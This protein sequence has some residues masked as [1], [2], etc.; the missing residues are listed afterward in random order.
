M[1]ILNGITP[2]FSLPLLL[3]FNQFYGYKR[4]TYNWRGYIGITLR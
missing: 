2:I 4:H 3:T 1:L